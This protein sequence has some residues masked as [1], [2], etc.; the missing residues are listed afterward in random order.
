MTAVRRAVELARAHPGNE[1]LP[2]EVEVDTVEQFEAAL[3]CRPDILIAD[4][5][6]TALDV[7][8]QAQIL[9]IL[10]A[11]RADKHTAIALISHDMGVIAGNADRVQVMRH[12]EVSL[13]V[14]LHH[15]VEFRL[16][17]VDADGRIDDDGLRHRW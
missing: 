15:Q 16:A 2:V 8:V 14:H 17:H 13:A 1:R 6:T 9:E 7:T 5:P 10:R 12:G 4:E 3:A 11:L